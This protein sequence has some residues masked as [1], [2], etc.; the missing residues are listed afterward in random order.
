MKK[1]FFIKTNVL[2]IYWESGMKNAHTYSKNWGDSWIQNNG[3]LIK[4]GAKE[5]SMLGA[6]NVPNN[7]GGSPSFQSYR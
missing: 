1:Y 3:W 7:I 6:F 4:W 2:R 5:G